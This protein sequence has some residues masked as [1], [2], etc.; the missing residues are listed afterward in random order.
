MI[1]PFDKY[2]KQYLDPLPYWADEFISVGGKFNPDGSVWVYHATTRDKAVQILKEGVLR[3]PPNTP[4]TYG[5]Y[6]S[7]SPNVWH[8]YGDGTV[9]PLKVKASD[10][11]LDDMF[12]GKRVDFLAQTKHGVFV[13][14]AIGQ[15]LFKPE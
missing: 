2:K 5:V 11:Q 10:L 8:D 13:P 15:P 3:R 14:L 9:I 6:V 1:N 12:P 7:S 4:D